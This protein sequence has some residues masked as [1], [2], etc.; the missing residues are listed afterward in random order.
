MNNLG[1]L[2]KDMGRMAEAESLLQKAV[3]LRLEPKTIL[4][5]LSCLKK[6]SFIPLLLL[7]ILLKDDYVPISI[8]QV[9]IFIKDDCEPVCIIQV[10]VQN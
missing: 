5:I 2:Y 9:H 6:P 10:Q 4:A 8:I 3:E 7:Y 1:N